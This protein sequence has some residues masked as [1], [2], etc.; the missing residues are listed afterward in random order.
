M[1]EWFSTVKKD[2]II[3]LIKVKKNDRYAIEL[4]NIA[5]GM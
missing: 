4:Y 1:L 5:D 2:I 3:P